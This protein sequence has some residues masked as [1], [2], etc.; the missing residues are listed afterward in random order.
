MIW[1]ARLDPIDAG[2]ARVRLGLQ[3]F[4]NW[5]IGVAVLIDHFCSGRQCVFKLF[6][7]D[8]HDALPVRFRWN[9]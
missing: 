4:E 5:I 7:A 3:S 1:Q 6:Y 8:C 2:L 9:G